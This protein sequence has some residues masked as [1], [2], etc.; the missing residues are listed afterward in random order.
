MKEFI[1]FRIFQS[2]HTL[3]SLLYG[4]EIKYLENKRI[5]GIIKM[6]FYN[7]EDAEKWVVEELDEIKSR[8]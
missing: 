1:Q 8:L 7:E 6:G 5:M 2:G 4:A 3:H